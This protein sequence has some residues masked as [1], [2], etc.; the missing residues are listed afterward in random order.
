[1]KIMS[2][3]ARLLNEI[4]QDAEAP[5]LIDVNSPLTGEGMEIEKVIDNPKIDD[6]SVGDLLTWSKGSDI[7]KFDQAEILSKDE[8]GKKVTLMYTIGNGRR[9]APR[10]KLAEYDSDEVNKAHSLFVIKK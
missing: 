7:T 5:Q 1:M 9:V 2:R 3:A 10:T 4:E 6:M 8:E